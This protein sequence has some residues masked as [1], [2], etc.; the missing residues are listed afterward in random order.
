LSRGAC[1]AALAALAA[2]LS[3]S[4]LRSQQVALRLGGVHARY[5]DAVTGS[6]G[7][8]TTRV[9]WER[10]LLHATLDG[11]YAQFSTGPWAVQAQGSIF[12]VRFVR[13]NVGLGLRLGVDGGYLARGIWSGT[14]EASPVLALV[15][16]PWMFSGAFNAG[17]V[18][19]TDHSALLLSGGGAQVRYDAGRWTLEADLSATHAGPINYADAS[20][21]GS[22]HAGAVTVSAMAGGRDGN[23]GGRPW[24]QASAS[25]ALTPTATVEAAGGSYPRDLSGFTGGSF[26]SIGMWL[27]LGRRRMSVA[28]TQLSQRFATGKSTLRVESVAP[29]HQEVTFHLPGARSVAIA[30]EWNEWTPVA[31][32]R[33]DGGRWRAELA[34]A[35][36]THRFALLVD[37]RKWTVPP[38][39]ARLPD[40]MGGEVGL[41]VIDQ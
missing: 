30:G 9:S 37:G 29:G 6:A 38:G 27:R 33:L 23:L 16:G 3:P 39:V 5:A 36:G 35:Q 11:S 31:L 21:G 41:L 25:W 7:T 4:P 17:A 19:R 8:F 34:L 24:Y 15:T 32:V 12:G 28:V 14:L 13:P 40:D 20:L 26:L 22:F 18:R 1:A 2:S 10:P